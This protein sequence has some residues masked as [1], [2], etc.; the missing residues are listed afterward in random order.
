[1]RWLAQAGEKLFFF[2]NES[3]SLSYQVQGIP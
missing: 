1:M 2:Q 3:K